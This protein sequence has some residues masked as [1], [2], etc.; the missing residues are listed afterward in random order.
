MILFFSG[1][2]TG[3]ILTIFVFGLLRMSDD[4]PIEKEG[5]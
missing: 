2:F 4:K 5:E 3:I 1:M